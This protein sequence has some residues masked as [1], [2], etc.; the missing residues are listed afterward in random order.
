MKREI[1]ILLII[2]LFVISGC[3]NYYAEGISKNDEKAIKEIEENCNDDCKKEGSFCENNKL[4]NCFKAENF[5]CFS[6]ELIEECSSNEK[7]T[8]DGCEEKK[9]YQLSKKFDLKGYPEPFIKD[10]E[11]ND[12]ILVVSTLGL[13]GE[14]IIGAD[15]Q[16]GLVPYVEE[17][18]PSP[19]TTRQISSIE[20]KNAILI[21]NPCTHQLIAEI[22][23]IEFN[24]EKCDSFIKDG[25]VILELYDNLDNEHVILLVMAKSDKDYKKGGLF[26]KYWEEHKDEFNGNRLVIT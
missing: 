14:I 10:R 24:S 22:K 17:K 26:L 8:L 21:G 9:I 16:S 6:A 23:N 12:Y 1:F 2:S 20:G 19:Y 3:K 13:N 5:K 7:C 11:F 4:Y 15:I 25:E 18:F